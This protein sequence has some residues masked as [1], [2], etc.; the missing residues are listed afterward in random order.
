MPN[1]QCKVLKSYF[2]D[3]VEWYKL[4]DISN[5]TVFHSPESDVRLA[6]CALHSSGGRITPKV[7]GMGSALSAAC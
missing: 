7:A 6:K 5:G 4:R 3:G 1:R 2:H